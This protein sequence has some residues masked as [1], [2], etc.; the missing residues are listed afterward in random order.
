MDKL[1][2]RKAAASS[3]LAI[4]LSAVASLAMAQGAAANQRG[5]DAT[6]NST[7]A[8]TIPWGPP[9]LPERAP[10][11]AQGP[12][13]FDPGLNSDPSIRDTDPLTMNGLWELLPGDRIVKPGQ[14]AQQQPQ[15]Q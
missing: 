6:Q 2:F 11:G 3:A 9:G 1:R 5:E 7:D 15:R 10:A 12:V 4:A 14:E 8:G 13:H